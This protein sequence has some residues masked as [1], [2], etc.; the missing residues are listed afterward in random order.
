MKKFT[1]MILAAAAAVSMTACSSGSPSGS[2]SS[3][4]GESDTYLVGICQLV[5]HVALDAATQGFMDELTSE[6]GD[7]VEFDKQ[8]ASGDP[9]T[10]TMIA[11]Q[12]VSEKVDL[13]LANATPALQAAASA[14]DSIP[15]LGTSITEYGVA[16]GINDFNGT[17]GTNV[18]GTSDLAPLGQQA[19]MFDELLP[20]A[21]NI[22]ILYCSAEANS[23]YQAEEV[24]KALETLGKT[25][26]VYTFSDSNDVA[27]V[28]ATACNEND[29]LYIPT[30]NTAASSA[31]AINNV[32]LPAGVPI[33][34]G[35]E[36]LCKGCGIASLSIDYYELGRAT[37]AMAVRVLKG[38]DISAMP[39][40]YY[41]NP[42]KKYN[43]E[44]C[45]ELGITVPSDYTAIE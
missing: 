21:K 43:A 27:S 22:G 42:V 23:V 5:Q 7:K 32:A 26:T 45:K 17:V 12:F 30:D 11:N 18:S 44:L 25:V 14:T 6:F 16:L 40:E 29:A 31:E 19:E 39:I 10:C 3:S 8:N 34:A 2:N 20:D 41:Q 35:E 13:M 36:G 15:V 1:S 38:E 4:G 24:K 33:I 28:T 37:G 9:A